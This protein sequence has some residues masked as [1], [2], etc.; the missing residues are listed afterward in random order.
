[1]VMINEITGDLVKQAEE[2]DVI[3]HGCNCFCTMKSGIAPQIKAKWPEAYEADLQT[4]SGDNSKL[5][6]ISC[7][8]NTIPIVVNAYIQY[9]YGRSKQHCNYQA[10]RSCFKEIKRRYSGYKIGLPRIGAGLAGGD[11][12]TIQQILKEELQHENVT[13]VKWIND[14]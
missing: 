7:T 13:I 2:F 11:W 4:K 10:L 9:Q 12:N 8:T 14:K 5:G 6:T 3:V 1:M